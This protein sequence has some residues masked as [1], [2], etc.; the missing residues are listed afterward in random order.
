MSDTHIITGVRFSDGYWWNVGT[1]PS[2]DIAMAVKKQL[3]EEV[4]EESYGDPITITYV[5]GPIKSYAS[6]ADFFHSR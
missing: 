5:V 1:F 3:L 2:F 6:A 4:K